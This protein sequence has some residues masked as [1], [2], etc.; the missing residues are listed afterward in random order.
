MQPKWSHQRVFI[1]GAS[2]GIG[3]A[4]AARYAALGATLG[5]LARRGPALDQL[6]ASLP[7]PERHRAYAVDVRDHAAIAAAAQDFIA[8]TGGIDVV[9]ANA[10]ISVGTLTEYADDLPVFADIV[11]TNLTATAATFAP[12]IATMKAQGAPARLVGIGSV[13]GIR[14]LPG[15]EA[16]SA[17]KAAVISYCESLRL[18]LKPYGIKVVTLCPGYIDTPMTRVNPYPMPF[19]MAPDKFAARAAQVIDAGSSY[20]VIPWQMGVVAKVLR[21][22]PNPVYDF[23]FGKAPHK[24]RKQ[25]S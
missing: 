3:A 2:S 18:E 1:T 14:G 17:S 5:L 7:Q 19:L 25:A 9:I 22:L 24:P 20:A 4:L 23:A 8:H 15:A 6:I 16:Y 12:F 13:A 21:L 11:A 10:G